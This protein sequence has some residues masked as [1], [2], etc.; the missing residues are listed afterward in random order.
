VPKKS[1]LKFSKKPPSKPP[2][3]QMRI[4]LVG[5]SFSQSGRQAEDVSEEEITWLKKLRQGLGK[6]VAAAW[7]IS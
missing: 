7:S 5:Q 2:Q 6:S 1:D 3:N 4:H